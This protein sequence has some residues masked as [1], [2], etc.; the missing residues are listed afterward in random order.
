MKNRK[1]TLQK[2]RRGPRRTSLVLGALAACSLVVGMSATSAS[3]MTISQWRMA[4]LNSG[5]VW[6]AFRSYGVMNYECIWVT[7]SGYSVD[8]YRGGR[9]VRTCGATG[10][11]REVCIDI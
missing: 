5:G 6:D 2:A 10:R 7:D 11:S 8:A 9:F 4:C 3:A 1:N